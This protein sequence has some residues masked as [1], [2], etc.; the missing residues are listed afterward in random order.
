MK[1]TLNRRNSIAHQIIS[2]TNYDIFNCDLHCIRF[3]LFKDD[4][5][6]TIQETMSIET[7]SSSAT[8][9]GLSFQTEGDAPI[10]NMSISDLDNFDAYYLGNTDEKNILNFRLWFR[11]RKYKSNSHCFK[12]TQ[13]PCYLFYC[14]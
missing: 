12:K 13:C 14:G 6:V 2:A 3:I 8:D 7:V 4:P 11:Q 10:G 9:W 5:D 1:I